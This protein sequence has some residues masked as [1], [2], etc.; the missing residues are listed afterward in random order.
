MRSLLLA[1][2]L[3]GVLLAGSVAQAPSPAVKPPQ[4]EAHDLLSGMLIGWA[5]PLERIPGGWLLCDGTQGTPDLR[6]RYLLGAAPKQPVG[7]TG[8]SNAATLVHQQLPSHDHAVAFD[9]AGAHKHEIVDRYNHVT[10]FWVLVGPLDTSASL[11][12]TSENRAL[13]QAGTHG[14]GGTLEAGPPASSFD[15]R[16]ASLR[17]AWLMKDRTPAKTFPVG[18]V[19]PWS[20]TVTSLPAGWDLCDGLGGR[21]DLMGRFAQGTAAAQQPGAQE[22]QDQLGLTSA[23]LPAHTHGLAVSDGKGFHHHFF[24]DKVN[25]P[26]GGIT[27]GLVPVPDI[28]WAEGGTS[29]WSTEDGEHTH[30]GTVG[31]TG[32]GHPLDTRPAFV[33]LPFLVRTSLAG[34]NVPERLVVPWCRPKAAFPLGWNACDGRGGRLDLRDRFLRGAFL[35]GGSGGDHERSLSSNEL[36]SHGHALGLDAAGKHKHW[37]EEYS[38]QTTVTIWT[39]GLVPVPYGYSPQVSSQRTT[40]TAPAHAHDP[41][42][43]GNAGGS[44]P[45]DNRPAFHRVVFLTRQ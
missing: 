24:S 30:T 1:P 20:D 44:Q 23:A 45:F 8:G 4:V 31:T 13:F 9:P 39:G 41:V 12:V 37:F 21:P 17:L 43:S 42:D 40:G 6:D 34:P 5:G 25:P 11:P 18:A 15:N 14:H 35:P 36:P 33:E 27:G 16:P 32:L 2:A 10:D 26:R 19:L 3:L 28:A 22:G 29:G 7:E 38:R